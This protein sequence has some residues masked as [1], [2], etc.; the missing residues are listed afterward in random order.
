[1]SKPLSSPEQLLQDNIQLRERVTFL[2]TSEG[3]R[4]QAELTLRAATEEW[5]QSF[6][7]LTDLNIN[8]SS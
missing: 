7:A 8:I 5:E 2:E 4:K 6:N 3:R 1:M